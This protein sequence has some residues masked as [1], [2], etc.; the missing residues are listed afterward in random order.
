MPEGPEAYKLI[1]SVYSKVKNKKLIGIRSNTKTKVSIPKKSKV[2]G[3]GN[4]G[5]LMWLKT[6]DYYL[7]IHL[8]ISGWLVVDKPRIYKYVLKFDNVDFYLQDRRRF[9]KLNVVTEKKHNKILDKLGIDIYSK[10]FTL[11]EFQKML[12]DRK[13]NISALLL[14]QSILAGVGNY[15]RNEA[16]YMAKV[17]PKRISNTLSEKEI[18]KLYQAIK[19]VYAANIGNKSYTFKVYGREKDIKGNKTKIEKIAGRDTY[20]VASIQK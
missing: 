12:Y 15:I 13:Q 5:K 20:W 8:G 9:S 7:H 1:R 17:S 4:K 19:K 6:E 3:Y 11:K 2:I 14:N 16:L 18:K 10:E